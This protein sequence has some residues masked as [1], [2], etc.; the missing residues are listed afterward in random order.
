[1]LIAG[2]GPQ[3]PMVMAFDIKTGERL[4]RRPLQLHAPPVLWG[5]AVDRDGRI[6]A[7]LKD[8]HVMCF[9]PGS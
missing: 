3:A 5:M 8:G 7:A 9:G 6:I 1:V 4:W 2:S